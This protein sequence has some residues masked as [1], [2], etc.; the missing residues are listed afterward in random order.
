MVF[1]DVVYNHFG[2][3]GN[4]LG[5][6]AAD[7]FSDRHPSPWGAAI[8]FD[9]TN[10]HWVRRFFIHNALYWLEE[11]HL[12][13]LRL[14]AVHAIHDDS[15]PDF[16]EE[17]AQAVNDG[18]AQT[19]PIHLVLEND[20]NAAHYLRRDNAGRPR[21]YTAQWND[22]LHHALHVIATGERDGYYQ[23]YLP[24]PIHHLGRCLAEGFA[25][26]GESSAY[27][28]QQLRGEASAALPPTAFVA[29]IQ[30]HDQVG[31]RPLGERLDRLTSGPMLKA[32][33]AI[34]LLAPSP[35]LLFMGQEWA[36]AR[37]FPFFCDF[38]DDLVTAVREGRRREL[39][40]MHGGNPQQ[41]NSY[42]PCANATFTQ[43]KLHWE[44][45]KQP[46]HAAWLAYHRKLL[47]LRHREIIPR[48]ENIRGDSAGYRILGELALMAWWSLGDGARLSLYANLGDAAVAGIPEPAGRLLFAT[49]AGVK[50]SLPPLSAVWYLS[51]AG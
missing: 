41:L 51:E 19:R 31:N 15:S 38:D 45:R 44:E 10:S 48:L 47:D 18:P 35:P 28:H 40:L 1:L 33:T 30:N 2:P 4:Y 50:G 16:L 6:Y 25:Y 12:D 20:D 34:V 11:F 21:A 8:N 14:D 7:F 26:Q 22:D 17:L 23:D 37:P 5:H 43:A 36:T 39:A 29:F 46:R 13:G 3:E 9:G 27:R 24:H 32:L 42:D 49:A